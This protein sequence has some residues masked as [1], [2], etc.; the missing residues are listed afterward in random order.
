[1]VRECANTVLEQLSTNQ[2]L[3]QDHQTHVILQM[4]H[5]NFLIQKLINKSLLISRSLTRITLNQPGTPEEQTLQHY[6][7]FGVSL[8]EAR[9]QLLENNDENEFKTSC[10][11]AIDIAK[12]HLTS[13]LSDIPQ[14]FFTVG[15]IRQLTLRME[16]RFRLPE[17]DELHMDHCCAI[18]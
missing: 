11:A 14:N 16:R 17:G 9:K 1:M 4:V 2:F 13:S 12:P 6:I 18:Q 7:S 10:L 5:F 15:S 3:S 8:L